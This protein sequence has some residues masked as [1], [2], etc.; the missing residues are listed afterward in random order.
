MRDSGSDFMRKYCLF[1]ESASAHSFSAVSLPKF[2][3]PL[4]SAF[5]IE[6]ITSSSEFDASWGGG[7]SSST[8]ESPVQNSGEIFFLP[9]EV[10]GGVVFALRLR[11]RVNDDE[12]IGTRWETS[13][14]CCRLW[15][16]ESDS[17]ASPRLNSV[18][19]LDKRRDFLTGDG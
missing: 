14:V 17:C 15:I 18:P 11:A 10:C 16:W 7:D 12:G 1:S 5:I 2:F 3:F 19:V 13:G 8:L 4:V 9:L 6:E